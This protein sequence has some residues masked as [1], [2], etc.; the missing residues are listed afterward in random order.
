MLTDHKPLVTIFGP[1]KQIPSL[2]AARIQRW[3]L[4]LG[5]HQYDIKYRKAWQHSNCDSL[6]TAPDPL[7]SSDDD[8]SIYRVSFIEELP[9]NATVIK[10][11][12]RKD[13][14][15]SRVQDL[16]LNGWPACLNDSNA[17]LQPYFI[18]RNELSSENNCILWGV[19]VVIP[20]KYQDYV[21]QELHKSHPEICRMKA[22][23]PSYILVASFR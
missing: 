3:A 9:V 22:L 23:A 2:A 15:L 6:S 11:A 21:L 1:K 12:T 8:D 7:T 17:D 5:L 20:P 16:I 4:L 10:E 14:V 19:T 13:T 18:R